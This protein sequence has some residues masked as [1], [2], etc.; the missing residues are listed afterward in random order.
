[1]T[2]Y[3]AKKFYN[4]GLYEA[5]I[6]S[7]EQLLV[8]DPEDVNAHAGLR[9]SRIAWI[10]HSLL[11]VRFMRMAGNYHGSMDLLLDI[12]N[13]ENQWKV[14]PV[15]AEAYTQEEETRHAQ[16][17][18]ALL[19]SQSL[20]QN[21]PLRAQNNLASY[22][23]FF[24]G[25]EDKS[26]FDTLKQR[27][28]L[29]AQAHCEYYKTQ[30]SASMYYF[31]KFITQYCNVWSLTPVDMS[32]QLIAM[33]QQFYSSVWVANSAQGMP[34]QFETRVKK[35]FMD[36]LENTPWYHNEGL[37]SIDF[38]LSGSFNYEHKEVPKDLTHA[39]TVSIP[40]EVSWVEKKEEPSEPSKGI[41]AFLEVV[42]AVASIFTDSDR[43]EVDN[44]NGTIT[45]YETRYRQETRHTSYRATE[46]TEI[47]QTNLAMN[48][49]MPASYLELSDVT[50]DRHSS[51][52][53]GNN[54]PSVNL[55]PEAVNLIGPSEFLQRRINEQAKQFRQHLINDWD[56][57]YCQAEA[58][59]DDFEFQI[60][61]STESVEQTLHNIE[62]L[63][64][65][66]EIRNEKSIPV[67]LQNWFKSHIGMNYEQ[68][69][70]LMENR[71]PK[72]E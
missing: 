71:K 41:W 23:S 33:Q 37:K 44:G 12:Y 54:M 15:G 8:L 13:K 61:A 26:F 55:Y 53:H 2:H 25:E 46:H 58:D 49:K 27:V 56:K 30:L 36:Q 28:F 68:A 32:E 4:D 72:E 70:L 48:A 64:R 6:A 52:S 60:F 20:S 7:Y 45:V 62:N 69:R 11:E 16:D 19:V 39:Y 22:S 42:V 21:Y 3:K 40:Y 5:S 67:E 31:S 66:M 50:N 9:R 57:A 1:M 51:I 63:F 14:F 10:A 34:D 17:A 18:V 43:R 59:A 35:A 65:C 47:F 24:Q 38:T 29:G